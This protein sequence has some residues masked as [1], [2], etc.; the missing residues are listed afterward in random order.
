M[1]II[2]K[3]FQN[4]RPFGWDANAK[5][6]VAKRFL[7]NKNISIPQWLEAVSNQ[8]TEGY[9]NLNDRIVAKKSYTELLSG[10]YFFPTSAALHNVLSGKG[11]L[12]GCIVYPL[13][14]DPEEVIQNDIAKI[15]QLLMKGIGV[16][17]NLSNL[18]PRLYPDAN[19]GRAMAGPVEMIQSIAHATAPL[20]DYGGLKKAAFMGSLS[21]THP[22]VTTFMSFKSKK[23]LSSVNVS[24]TIDSSFKKALANK[25]QIP[26][27]FKV[28]GKEKFLTMEVWLRMQQEALNR[29]L[30]PSDLQITMDGQ[31]KSSSIDQ[32]IGSIQSN[33]FHLDPAKM[34]TAIST[35]AHATGDPGILDLDAINQVN[36]T[37]PRYSDIKEI[38]GQGEIHT[39]TPCGEQPLLPYEVCHLGS[40][41]LHAFLEEDGYFNEK[42]FKEAIPVAVQFMDDLI[43]RSDN[44]LE[45]ANLISKTNRKIGIGVMGLADTLAEI[46]IPYD[47]EKARNFANYIA[48][49]LQSEAEKASQKLAT[50]RGAFKT[51]AI[52]RAALF[53]A[54]PQRHATLTTI[55]PTGHIS[56]LAGCSS[57]IEPYYLLEYERLAAG[58][59]HVKNP[60]LEKKLAKLDY[61]LDEWIAATIRKTPSYTFDGT[62]KGLIDDPMPDATKNNQLIKLKK[63]F[64]T[65]GEIKP[66]NHLKMVAVFQKII[67]NGVSKTINLPK[68]ATVADVESVFK[69][70]IA[71]GLKGMTVYRDQSQD[72]QALYMPK[73]CLTCD[74]ITQ[75]CMTD[76]VQY[77][78]LLRCLD[79]N[80]NVK[81]ELPAILVDTDDEYLIYSRPHPLV[82]HY[83][84]EKSFTLDFPEILLVS[85]KE[86]H[87]IS[88]AFDKDQAVNMYINMNM[89]PVAHKTGH[90]W[91]DLELD[92]KLSRQAN[93]DWEAV[94]VDQDEFEKADLTVEQRKIA[95]DEVQ[96]LLQKIQNGSF[97]FSRSLDDI[98]KWVR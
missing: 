92:I 50:I 94:V 48:L 16:G 87:C 53:D 29:G 15:S 26:F 78:H 59:L 55:A 93:G 38:L 43:E 39:T 28:H 98:K 47:S 61:S 79:Y 72:V 9:A 40:F 8:T 33:I 36:P 91:I 64:V 6:L 35:L 49:T 10:R 69:E 82:H 14:D 96:S 90:E 23:Q 73:E 3:V 52:S 17:L 97:P 27:S 74:P 37:H 81:Y 77:T 65:S 32:I 45:I 41:N 46:E 89:P 86:K 76:N 2:H 5:K 34:L 63:V 68:Q 22:D 84:K 57:S 25:E 70:A 83:V 44:G 20:A 54:I 21:A 66:K 85:K 56:T 95:T 1:S 67:D 62:L 75:I 60:I 18:P 31:I 42:K 51:F 30:A 58:V 7:P 13:K 88:I 12:A 71:F 11:S 80:G 19:T 4:T 24:V